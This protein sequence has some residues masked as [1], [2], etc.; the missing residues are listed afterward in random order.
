VTADRT[1]GPDGIADGPSRN[2][3]GRPPALLGAVRFDEAARAAAAADFGRIVHRSPAGV[4]LP[5]APSDVA[6]A[7][8]WAAERG[9]G[10]AAQGS[11]HSVYG[12]AQV[13]DGLVADMTRLR[14]VHPVD[15]NEVAVD[16]G[17]TWRQ[18]LTATLP[19]G[20]APPVLPDHLDL[21][22][23]GTLAVGGVGGGIARYGVVTDNVVELA[24]VTGRGVEATCSSNRDRELFDAVRAGLG[25][26]AVI[27]GVTLRLVA[28]PP[29]VRQIRLS[30]P[31]LASLLRDQRL[32]VAEDRFDAVQ[33][34]VLP[35]P[36]GSWS[37]RLDVLA[38]FSANPPDDAVL[39]AGLSDDRAKAQPRTV[40]LLEHLARLDALEQALRADGTWGRPH[41]WLTTFVGDAAVE[42]AVDAELARLAPA[43]LGPLGQVVVSA[44]PASAVRT[45]LLRLPDGDLVHAVNLI[46][47]PAGGGAVSARRLVAANRAA[48]ER[49]RA[50]GGT[51]YPASALPMS[52]ADWRDHFGPAFPAF[53]AARATHDPH[54]VLTPGY[55]VFL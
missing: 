51:L 50:A 2:R 49:I 45:P 46:R 33:G 8:R 37:Y 13:A 54:G 30:Y 36:D 38:G 17:A 27:T 18:V 10:F 1:T 15:G 16:A 4:L 39:L 21:T 35:A 53:A 41:P 28:A 55:E 5:D 42:A 11:R 20:L 7:I 31:D 9:R 32:L 48:Y 44:F 23:G 12:R 3:V 25:Q 14:T 52:A 47:L 40:P 26:V 29:R 43:D 24:V 19:H 22:V 6:T 34:A